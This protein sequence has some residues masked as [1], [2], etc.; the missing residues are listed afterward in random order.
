M[1]RMEK[2][3][4]AEADTARKS[5]ALYIAKHF[6]LLVNDCFCPNPAVLASIAGCQVKS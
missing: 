5:A 2:A 1:S 6:R 4:A 3:L